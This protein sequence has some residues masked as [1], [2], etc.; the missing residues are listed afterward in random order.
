V[1]FW[2][3]KKNKKI[4]EGLDEVTQNNFQIYRRLFDL[5]DFFLRNAVAY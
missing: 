2:S 5:V 3:F 4:K 1:V